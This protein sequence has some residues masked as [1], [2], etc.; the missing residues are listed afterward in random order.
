[1]ARLRADGFVSE[2]SLGRL[3]PRAARRW[4]ARRAVVEGTTTLSYGE[5]WFAV[6]SAAGLLRSSGV[7][8]GDRVCWQTPNWWEAHAAALAIWHVGAVNCPIPMLNR[9]LELR[10]ILQELRPSAV[11]APG[12][13]RGFDHAEAFDQIC[14]EEGI[15]T[16]IKL[17]L[18][19]ERS[20]WTSFE[21]ALQ[22]PAD[23]AGCEIGVE[24]PCLI[25]YTS[26]TSSGPKGV[27][28]SPRAVLSEG[29]QIAREWTVGR[30]D[31]SYMPAPLGHVTGVGLGIVLPLL[32]GGCSVLSERWDPERAVQEIDAHRVTVSAG[33]TVFLR[34]L[35]DAAA[36]R[37]PLPLREYACG[38]AA[39]PID[40]MDAAEAVG[41]RAH[42]CYGMTENSSVTLASSLDP[43]ETRAHT[44][45]RLAE[46]VEAFT[47][48]T[49]GNRLS[50]GEVGEIVVRGPE[51]M[52]GYVDA[53]QS[54]LALDADGWFRTGDLGSLDA[55]GHLSVIGRLKDII[56][57][58]GEKFATGDIERLILGAP[59]VAAAAVVPASDARFGEVPA[60][61][62]VGS[63]T[64]ESLVRHLVDAGIAKQKIPVHWRF[65]DSLP[66][67][68]SG[69]VKKHELR[70]RLDRELGGRGERLD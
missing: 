53:A 58:G 45:G 29:Q 44:D 56:N 42:R 3:L 20:G 61:F 22:C 57:R 6:R 50:V 12:V 18:R 40:V 25:L 4:P 38:G 48:D 70:A 21:E 47:I 55:D 63:A 19:H 51:R 23:D 8:A 68:P 17:G 13:V 64:T 16:K 54:A 28:L 7:A 1:M 32:V 9:E 69:K 35:A 52:L 34:E 36:G 62:V 60:A 5:L 15:E 65:V 14:R 31:A 30:A 27:M 43:Y 37:A 59:D 49:A 10:H 67:T 39:V 66:S 33:A 46:G 2:Q 24:S 26:G 41:V 11:I